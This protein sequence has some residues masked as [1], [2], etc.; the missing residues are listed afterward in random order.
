[1]EG[2]PEYAPHQPNPKALYAERK[3]PRPAMFTEYIKPFESIIT[4]QVLNRAA[5]YRPKATAGSG[6]QGCRLSTLFR[7]GEAIE[8]V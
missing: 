4:A 7:P 1:M 2:N 6:T 8:A 5:T 3:A